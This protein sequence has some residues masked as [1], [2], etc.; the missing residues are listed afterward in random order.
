MESAITIIGCTPAPDKITAAAA[1]ISTTTGDAMAI[2]E[3]ATDPAKNARLVQ[4]VLASGHRSLVEHIVFNLACVNVSAYVEQFII[5]Y[6]L[7]SF[8]VKSRRYVDFSG[9]GCVTPAFVDANGV[10]LTGAEALRADYN[11]HMAYLF[12]EYGALVADGIPR[13]D[14]RFLL[15]YSYRSNFYCTLNAREL[16]H[17]LYDMVEGRGRRNSEIYRLGSD[18]LAQARALCPF[19]FDDLSRMESGADD[20]ARQIRDIVPPTPSAAAKAPVELL[21]APENP[22]RAVAEA[23]LIAYTGRNPG[24]IAALLDDDGLQ[25][26]IIAVVLQNRRPREL[27]QIAFTFRLNGVSL[28]AVTHLTRHR[29]QSLMVPP[30]SSIAPGAPYIT[31]PSIAARPDWR[32]RYAAAFEKTRALHEKLLSAGLRPEE[33]AYCLMSG[34]TV[35]VVTTMNARELHIFMALR[36]CTR[37]QWETRAFAI[38]MLNL[39]REVSPALF[40]R[41]GPSCFVDGRCPEGPKTCGRFSEMQ[42]VFSGAMVAED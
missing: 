34:H 3:A 41:F 12:A 31:P 16:C 17:L 36:T 1:R 6:R 10:P 32:E 26:K 9:M 21:H 14:A 22:A 18:L 19:V 24:D 33:A 20:K 8:T 37:A 38:A 40:G 4:K 2:F 5:E 15:P 11:A 23:A 13:E 28:P 39:L 42:A 27:E 35:D 25:S 30:L 7:A 29:M